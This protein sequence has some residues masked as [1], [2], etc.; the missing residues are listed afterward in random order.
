MH[1]NRFLPGLALSRPLAGFNWGILLRSEKGRKAEWKGTKGRVL[2]RVLLR[3]Y[4]RDGDPISWS[5]YADIHALKFSIIR[6][7]LETVV[8]LQFHPYRSVPA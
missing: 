6:T 5:T 3:I 1:Q 7:L 2:N 8:M 4:A